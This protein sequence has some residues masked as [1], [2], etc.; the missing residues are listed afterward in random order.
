MDSDSAVKLKLIR[1]ARYALEQI[2]DIGMDGS[3]SAWRQ[4]FH[5]SVQALR[6]VMMSEIPPERLAEFEK[7]YDSLAADGRFDGGAGSG[8]WGHVGRPGK[9]GG[10]GKG[11]GVHNRSGTKESGYSSAAKERAKEKAAKSAGQLSAKSGG[12][13]P[14]A[15]GKNIV[16]SHTGGGDIKSVIHA[17]GFDGLPKCV[18]RKEFDK[19][20]ESSN[21]IAQRTYAATSQEI[22]DAYH[23]QLC[24]GEWYVECSEGGAFYGQGMYCAADYTGN[25]SEGI[26]SEMALYAKIGHDKGNPYVKT[27]TLTL[28]P[29][30]KI[31]SYTDVLRAHNGELTDERASRFVRDY[32]EPKLKSIGEKYGEQAETAARWKFGDSSISWEVAGEAAKN[33]GEEITAKIVEEVNGIQSGAYGALNAYRNQF[34]KESEEIRKKYGDVG[35][36]A[37]A[38]GYDAINADVFGVSHTVILNRTKTII[39]DESVPNKDG[40]EHAIRFRLGA[41]GVIYAIKDRK[42]IGCVYV[43][44]ASDNGTDGVSAS[45]DT[46]QGTQ[47]CDNFVTPIDKSPNFDRI[48]LENPN[49]DGGPGSGNFGHKGVPGQ[50]G[51]TAPSNGGNASASSGG[52]GNSTGNASSST[53]ASSNSGS[54]STGNATGKS[55]SSSSAVP[56]NSGNAQAAST[57]DVRKELEARIASGAISTKLDAK[58]QSDH[59]V[60]SNRYNKRIAKGDHPSILDIPET[61]RQT[62]VDN[63]VKNGD[64]KLRK[65]GSIRI[66]FEHSSNVG[67]WVSKDGSQTAKTTRGAIHLS[68]TGAHIVPE[69]PKP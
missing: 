15:E 49:T 4:V 67:T 61:D 45:C 32:A 31:I 58:K 6:K 11:G 65:N 69:K 33:V 17:Q 47:N 2:P 21:F 18:G 63:Y 42:V 44:G 64:A 37:A 14:M 12:V 20:V 22:L 66:Q 13:H 35:A 43:H 27:E 54:G 41:D 53:S 26:R 9:V 39:L 40:E 16:A 36:Y 3:S 46:K 38:L 51:G 8:N 68:K 10:S 52:T 50:V 59:I 1:L 25:L 5:S 30:A 60:G 19:A 7:V 23:D 56:G 62:F 29:S 24:N 57:Q 48:K 55:A 34:R 28:D